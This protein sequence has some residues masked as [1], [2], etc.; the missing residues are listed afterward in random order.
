MW[1]IGGHPPKS[2]FRDLD[3]ADAIRLCEMNNALPCRFVAKEKRQ[4]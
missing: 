2:N 3:F 4:V 1:P